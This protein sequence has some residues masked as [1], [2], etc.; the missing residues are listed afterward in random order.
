MDVQLTNKY[1]CSLYYLIMGVLFSHFNRQTKDY[2]TFF[3]YKTSVIKKDYRIKNFMKTRTILL[4]AHV[5]NY[6]SWKEKL[7]IWGIVTAML[8]AI[9]VLCVKYRQNVHIKF[10]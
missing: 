2:V 3:Y 8:N 1:E 5:C 4:C 7:S 9:S 10:L 6:R